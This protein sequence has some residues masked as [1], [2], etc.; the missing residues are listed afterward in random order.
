MIILASTGPVIST[1]RQ[2]SALGHRR[3]LPVAGADVRGFRQEVGHL[4]GVDARLA[5]DACL[6]QFLAAA[7]EGAMQ[8]GDQ[9]QRVDGQDG[10]V[11][12]LDRAGDCTP[13]GR[14]RL[15]AAPD[16]KLIDATRRI[17]LLFCVDKNSSKIISFFTCGN[18]WTVS[19]RLRP[20]SRPPRAA[21]FPPRRGSRG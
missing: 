6:E 13:C 14:L 21:A 7:F 17:L 9:R 16:E 20:L 12:R 19:S 18:K 1:R 15:M 3:D 11:T 4:A 5:S 8:P 2:C 10:F